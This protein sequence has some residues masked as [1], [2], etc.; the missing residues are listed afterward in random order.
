MRLSFEHRI[1]ALPLFAGVGAVAVLATSVGLG[2]RS[3]RELEQ[4][5]QRYY[6]SIELSRSLESSLAALQRK[7]QDA[8]A[9][10]DSGAV[11]SADSLAAAFRA[12]L[13]AARANPQ[14]RSASLD[15]VGSA[16]DVYIAL[17][18]STTR[19]MIRGDASEA[20]MAAL[21]TMTAQFRS[22][23]QSLA[24]Q[25]AENTG[26]I[27]AAFAAAR[28]AQQTSAWVTVGALF[29][30]TLGL[31][32]LSFGARAYL[33]R[34][35]RDIASAAQKVAEGDVRQ[36]IAHR[37]DDVIG[38]VADSFRA[39]IAYL[40][41][42]GAAADG[43]ARGDLSVQVTP[44]SESDLVSR[45][46]LRAIET[47]R[48]LVGDTGALIEAARAGE[49]ARRGDAAR[50][51]GA[52]AELVAGTNAMLDAVS[53]PTAEARAVLERVAE[54][55][56]TARMAGVYRGDHAAFQ[57][58]LNSA[59]D[60][61]R[62]ALAEVASASLQVSDVAGGITTSSE[63][64]ASSASRQAEVLERFAG[65]MQEITERTRG[66]SG[67]AQEARGLV[68]STVASSRESSR[69]VGRMTDAMGRISAS[70]SATARIVKT[71]DEI[72]FQTNLL[73]LNAAV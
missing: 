28:R 66:N 13:A 36:T 39:M 43:L 26:R 23:R 5:E 73:A 50:Y 18:S 53:A 37:S 24:A 6:P 14:L 33:S 61:L 44:R 57:S 59:L 41:Q 55:D 54:R 3:A 71:I 49:L 47:L 7:L 63:S 19:V 72:A 38:A 58:A 67:R 22:L 51:D 25:T 29:A 46:M 15:S 16:F 9:A 40:Q 64:L 20:V 68:S 70:S 12:E 60:R 31:A 30:I 56:L 8:V 27:G 17:A 35:L 21:P 65:R 1:I 48:A 62:D 69:Q 10:S 34:T 52:Y 4:V 45:N 2:R 32:I 42:V 11:A